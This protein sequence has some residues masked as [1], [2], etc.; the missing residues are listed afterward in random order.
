MGKQKMMKL[1]E[2][3]EYLNISKSKL[4]EMVNEA[5]VPAFKVGS[6]WRFNPEELADFAKSGVTSAKSQTAG[7]SVEQGR[8]V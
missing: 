4:Y 1:P 5:R 3:A 7:E 6:H 8:A 2:A